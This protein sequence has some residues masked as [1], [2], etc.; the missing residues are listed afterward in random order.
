MR[1][2]TI[3]K[4]KTHLPVYL[5]VALVLTIVLSSALFFLVSYTSNVTTSNVLFPFSESDDSH[6]ISAILFSPR[7]LSSEEYAGVLLFHGIA[8]HKEYMHNYGFA[9]ASNGFSALCVDLRLWGWSQDLPESQFLLQIAIRSA[10]F[11]MN[12]TSLKINRLAVVGHSLGMGVALMLAK[13]YP[14]IQASILIGNEF[15]SGAEFGIPPSTYWPLNFTK[16]RN[17]LYAISPNDEFI[18]YSAAVNYFST[19]V[20]CT[21]EEIIPFKTFNN[22]F[23][24]GLARR[25]VVTYS[26]HLFLL[27]DPILITETVN[28]L[29]LAF[30]IDITSQVNFLLREIVLTFNALAVILFLLFIFLFGV[31][32]I[33]S[34]TKEGNFRPTNRT[35][36]LGTPM[37][38]LSFWFFILGLLPMLRWFR[39][40]PLFFLQKL[41]EFQFDKLLILT[42]FLLLSFAFTWVLQKKT[43]NQ[44]INSVGLLG[45]TLLASGFLPLFFIFQFLGMISFFPYFLFL[46]LLILL[47]IGVVT[48]NVL[49]IQFHSSQWT[50]IIRSVIFGIILAWL[51]NL[52]I[53]WIS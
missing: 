30:E 46:T 33:F 1:L 24:A 11:L 3:S 25:I 53:P 19:A 42:V 41:F 36:S 52:W 7:V 32:K 39:L 40:N 34:S 4:I 17:L 15:S 23:T 29:H 22:N 37:L 27:V 16:P 5:L 45:V 20:D 21:P 18:S 12:I 47:S 26:P 9:L 8:S 49:S 31:K 44:E 13:T 6:L 10:E 51:F 38:C 35:L 28:W 2:N 14:A 43:T 48:I 50:L